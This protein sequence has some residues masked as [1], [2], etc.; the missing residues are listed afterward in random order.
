MRNLY[1][2]RIDINSLLAPSKDDL[3]KIVVLILQKISMHED[4]DNPRLNI[5]QRGSAPVFETYE[6]RVKFMRD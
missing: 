2:M 1:N 3:R 4:G 6:E 5:S